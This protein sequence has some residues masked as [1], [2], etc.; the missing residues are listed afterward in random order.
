MP[1]VVPKN[2]DALRTDGNSKNLFVVI[3]SSS[4]FCEKLFWGDYKQH[5]MT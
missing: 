4:I 2:D 3:A 5:F 1:G